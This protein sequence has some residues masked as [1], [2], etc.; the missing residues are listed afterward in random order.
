MALVLSVA[1]LVDTG[2]DEAFKRKQSHVWHQVTRRRQEIRR[3]R[4]T[5]DIDFALEPCAT[6]PSATL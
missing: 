4:G 3:V 5:Y 1:E 2:R 6:A